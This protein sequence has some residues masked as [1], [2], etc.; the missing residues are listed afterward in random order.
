[1]QISKNLQAF[2]DTLAWSEGTST[3]PAT[4]SNGYDVIVTGIDGKPEIFTDYSDHPFNKGRPSKQINSRG[5]TSNASGRYQFMLKDWAHYK[6]QLGLP[7]F[8]PESQDKW[9]IQLI[10]ERKAL[11]D[12]EVG[13][14]VSAVNKCRNIWASLPGA[15][16]GQREHNMDDLIARYKA[17]GGLVT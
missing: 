12:I 3:S 2:L 9:A 8:G 13:N 11:P 10:K 7:D 16:Y 14:I 17:A 1:M 6:A 4:K 5:L 15:G